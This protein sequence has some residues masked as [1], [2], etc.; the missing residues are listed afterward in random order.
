[1]ANVQS[2][3][4]ITL[5]LNNRMEINPK[6]SE[7]LAESV[8]IVGALLRLAGNSE[9]LFPGIRQTAA[10]LADL[11]DFLKLG[12]LEIIKPLGIVGAKQVCKTRLCFEGAGFSGASQFFANGFEV[13]ATAR[14]QRRHA[15]NHCVEIAEVAAPV[16]S[17]VQSVFKETL[18]SLSVE[19]TCCSPTSSSSANAGTASRNWKTAFA[20]RSCLTSLWSKSSI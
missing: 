15:N 11:H 3:L 18:F 16:R 1:M 6:M 9:Q 14:G 17:R 10:R 5:P 4:P 13:N 20:T 8:R 7:I 19:R 2:C 12:Q